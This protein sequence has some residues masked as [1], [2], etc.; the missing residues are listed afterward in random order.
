MPYYQNSLY[1]FP[2]TSAV[3]NLRS[4]RESNSN[5]LQEMGIEILSNTPLMTERTSTLMFGIFAFSFSTTGKIKGQTK[6]I[7]TE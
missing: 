3:K 2:Y 5:L 6:N 4:Y 7:V 1:A